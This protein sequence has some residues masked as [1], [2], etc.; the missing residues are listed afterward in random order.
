MGVERRAELASDAQP[1]VARAGQ[2]IIGC[3]PEQGCGASTTMRWCEVGAWGGVA[4]YPVA[5]DELPFS[6][7]EAVEIED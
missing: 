4:L 6:G 3:L 1:S 5:V 7:G 2:T